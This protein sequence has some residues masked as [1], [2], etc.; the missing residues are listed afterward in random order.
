MTVELGP[1]VTTA[2]MR[3]LKPNS[4]K[5]TEKLYELEYDPSDNLAERNYET[6]QVNDI[7]IYDMRPL[8]GKLSLDR[9]GVLIIDLPSRM[10]Y[11]D[12]LNEEELKK[13]YAEEL[14]ECLL[15]VLGAQGIFI[16]E[17]VVSRHNYVPL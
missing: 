3:F 16:H 4:W 14:R 12:F 5:S 1:A 17:C 10:A 7:P 11:E 13:V 8:K 6:Q 15:N 2:S 9:E